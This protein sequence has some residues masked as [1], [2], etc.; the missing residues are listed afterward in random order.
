MS[1]LICV[2]AACWVILW[3]VRWGGLNV[4]KYGIRAAGESVCD[5][6][7]HYWLSLCLCAHVW[8]RGQRMTTYVCVCVL[9]QKSIL[10][11][12]PASKMSIIGMNDHAALWLAA[13]RCRCWCCPLMRE[14]QIKAWAHQQTVWSPGV[15]LIL[16]SSFL[17]R[18][19]RKHSVAWN[20]SIF[21]FLWSRQR[22][23][24][25]SKPTR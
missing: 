11:M 4:A 20:L 2:Y 24:S 18:N 13:L 25:S 14:G 1:L 7:L 8:Q 9:R 15:S 6:T 12:G 16:P 22:F 10:P 19:K 23:S 17:T 5:P 21:V 3:E